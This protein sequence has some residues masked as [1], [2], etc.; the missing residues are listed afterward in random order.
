M[1]TRGPAL[2]GSRFP[3]PHPVASSS[4]SCPALWPC[5]F[6]VTDCVL[7]LGSSSRPRELAEGSTHPSWHRPISQG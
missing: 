3:V 5:L 7:R 2:P 6:S 4:T 1:D